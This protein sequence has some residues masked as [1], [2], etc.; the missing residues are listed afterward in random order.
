[1]EPTRETTAEE[2]LVV[3]PGQFKSQGRVMKAGEYEDGNVNDT[4]PATLESNGTKHFILI[5][6]EYT[7]VLPSR[8]CHAKHGPRHRAYP[9]TLAEFPLKPLSLKEHNLA[10]ALVQFK[11]TESVESQASAFAL[12]FRT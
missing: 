10:R 7:G 1:M 12:L 5:P 8:T 6:H 11:L 9:Q 4:F 3:V 2:N